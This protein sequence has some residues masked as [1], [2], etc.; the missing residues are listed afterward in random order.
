MQALSPKI[1]ALQAAAGD[2][3]LRAQIEDQL[4]ERGRLS[5]YY[6]PSQYGG[7]L[8]KWEAISTAFVDDHALLQPTYG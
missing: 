6:L 7:F 3:K 4:G 2:A 8:E 5:I 1:D